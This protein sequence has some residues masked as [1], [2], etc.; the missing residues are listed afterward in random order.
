M[1]ISVVPINAGMLD[2]VWK[3]LTK[4]FKDMELHGT[5]RTKLLKSVRILRIL[6][7]Y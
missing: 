6:L 3:S 5:I 4:S 2:T 1:K 7:E